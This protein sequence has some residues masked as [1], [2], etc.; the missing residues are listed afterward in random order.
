MRNLQEATADLSDKA[1]ETHAGDANSV[2]VGASLVMNMSSRRSVRSSSEHWSMP[3]GGGR[4]GWRRSRAARIAMPAPRE[5]PVKTTGGSCVVG[6][7]SCSNAAS[8]RGVRLDRPDRPDRPA[9]A[10]GEGSTEDGD[11]D[12][13]VGE[14]VEAAVLPF[15]RGEAMRGAMSGSSAE[16]KAVRQ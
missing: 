6:C 5:W 12:E 14:M 4:R 16:G 13:D 2:H 7:T 3:T 15:A 1:G 9:G 10:E 8:W 11:D